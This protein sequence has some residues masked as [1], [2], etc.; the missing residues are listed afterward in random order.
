MT[1][2]LAVADVFNDALVGRQFPIQSVGFSHFGNI[3][4]KM[5]YVLIPPP[6]DVSLGTALELLLT[7]ALSSDQAVTFYRVSQRIAIKR[8]A[9]DD[10]DDAHDGSRERF[11]ASGLAK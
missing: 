1:K 9:A 8:L 6:F 7:R 5:R 2:E 3:E 4:G 10:A 11:Q